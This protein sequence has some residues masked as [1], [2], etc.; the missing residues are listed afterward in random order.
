MA[1]RIEKIDKIWVFKN[2]EKYRFFMIELNL[3]YFCNFL[4][5]N[6]KVRSLFKMKKNK[7]IKYFVSITSNEQDDVLKNFQITI[8]EKR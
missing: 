4:I 5:L 7:I 2:H 6:N 3:K 8:S 1:F